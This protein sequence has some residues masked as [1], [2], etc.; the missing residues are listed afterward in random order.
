MTDADQ[1]AIETVRRMYKGE[2]SEIASIAP[3][4]L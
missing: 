4:I 2:E 3:D 1:R